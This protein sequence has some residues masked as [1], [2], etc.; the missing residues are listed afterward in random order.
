MYAPKRT[1]WWYLEIHIRFLFIFSID[2]FSLFLNCIYVLL[3]NPFVYSSFAVYILLFRFHCIRL[4]KYLHWA[5]VVKI[6]FLLFSYILRTYK[7]VLVLQHFL[8][9]FVLKYYHLLM[10]SEFSM[11]CCLNWETQYFTMFH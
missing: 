3:S 9:S 11:L 2:F 5:N 4:T 10:N 8:K 7:V 1:N 6:V